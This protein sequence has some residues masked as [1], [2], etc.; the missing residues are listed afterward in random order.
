MSEPTPTPKKRRV[1]IGLPVAAV[2][3]LL[4]GL[5]A[6]PTITA[7]FSEEQLNRN[8]LLSGIGFLMVF[9]SIILFYI[10]F[11]WWLA[12]R[13]NGKVAYKT[14]RIIEYIIIAGIILGIVGMFQSWV[15]VAFRYGFYL[16]LLATVAFIAWSHVTP[17]P[18]ETVVSEQ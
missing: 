5:F 17:A 16:L 9:I 1:P 11:I 10:S 13:L 15:F 3:F 4:L 14:Y 8:A 12:L 6:A 7:S 18:E 2:L